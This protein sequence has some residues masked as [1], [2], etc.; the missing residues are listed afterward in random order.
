GSGHYS[1]TGQQLVG[2]GPATPQAGTGLAYAVD[3]GGFVSLASPLRSGETI[4]ARYSS[5]AVVGS[6]TDSGGSAFDM[7]IAIPAPTAA[8]ALA[9]ISGGYWGATLEFGSGSLANAH[10]TISNFTSSG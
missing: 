7:F 6:T 1:F 9:S 8:A 4:N 2:A 3:P 5:E 10:S